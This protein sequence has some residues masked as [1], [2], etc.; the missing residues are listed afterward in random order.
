MGIVNRGSPRL[1]LNA[2]AYELFLFGLKHHITLVVE[3]APREEN[4][5]ADDLSKMLMPND[6]A[7]S[8]THFLS[9]ELQ[10]GPHTIGMFA[11]VS[12]NLCDMLYSLHW[13]MGSG[14]VNAFAY[15]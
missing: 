3:W 6:F 12:S 2:I 7:I 15:D 1:K 13:C 14:G 10:F 8:R 11:T 5:L 9:W 4:T